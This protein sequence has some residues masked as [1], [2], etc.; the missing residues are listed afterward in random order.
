MRT[1][2]GKGVCGV[3]PNTKTNR[4]VVSNNTTFN[5][6]YLTLSGFEQID[7]I[8]IIPCLQQKG[9]DG[10]HKFFC[11]FC[12]AWHHH[13][14]GIGHRV[15]HCHLRCT[16]L[17]KGYY[18]RHMTK[19]EHDIFKLVGRSFYIEG[20]MEISDK[21]VTD[22]LQKFYKIQ[23]IPSKTKKQSDRYVF[24]AKGES[25]SATKKQLLRNQR[26]FKLIC[27]VVLN[28]PQTLTKYEYHW[29]C[30]MI[31]ERAEVV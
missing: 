25:Y 5:F 28:Q 20:F 13:G 31:F 6:K 8:P 11:P 19:P 9:V 29:I 14:I 17:N 4:Q 27:L 1:K 21:R 23:C 10:M 15:E 7:G 30:D 2:K 3:Q 16:P 12:N 26:A 24:F 22:L 18:I